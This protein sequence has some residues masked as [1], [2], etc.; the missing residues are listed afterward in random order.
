[1]LKALAERSYTGHS[2]IHATVYLVC[3]IVFPSFVFIARREEGLLL[4]SVDRGL[5]YQGGPV[6]ADMLNLS[7][8]TKFIAEVQE[9]LI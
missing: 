6:P 1:M 8:N 9:C 5:R 2:L 7:C 3:A 4:S